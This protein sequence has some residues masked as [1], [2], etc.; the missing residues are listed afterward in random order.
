VA[1]KRHFPSSVVSR[2]FSRGEVVSPRTSSRIACVSILACLL[3]FS[4]ARAGVVTLAWDASP[5]AVGYK[6]YWG[7]VSGQYTASL[8]VGNVLRYG[9]DG[10]GDCTTWFFSVTAYDA[11]GET[12][13]SNEI[14]SAPGTVVFG[15]EI[16]AATRD[17]LTWVSP[18]DVTFVRGELA[19]VGNYEVNDSGVLFGA[20]SLTDAALPS[21]GMGFYYLLRLAGTCG[22]GSWQSV[23]GAEPG[24][25]ESLH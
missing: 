18:A 20:T 9:L 4:S 21:E 25:D 3:G 7:L 13:Y 15:E 24:R 17:T 16:H 8:D 14:S 5:G 19:T 10:F 6:V 2:E 23:L 22:V 1:R 11:A 12:G